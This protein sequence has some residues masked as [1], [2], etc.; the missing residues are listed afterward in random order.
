MAENLP[1]VTTNMNPKTAK[2]RGLALPLSLLGWA[3]DVIE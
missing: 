1:D 3:E 2:A